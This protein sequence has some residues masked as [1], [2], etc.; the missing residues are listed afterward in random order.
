VGVLVIGLASAHALACSSGPALRQTGATSGGGAS[1]AGTALPPGEVAYGSGGVPQ[2][3]L[4]GAALFGTPQLSLPL[5]AAVPGGGAIVAMS[6]DPAAPP[7]GIFVASIDDSCT[8]RWRVTFPTDGSCLVSSV[9]VGSGGEIAVAGTMSA[10]TLELGTHPITATGTLSFFVAKIDASGV[11]VFGKAFGNGASVTGETGAFDPAVAMDA[12][13]AVTVAGYVKGPIDFGGGPLPAS[14]GATGTDTDVFVAKLDAQGNYVY[15][16]RYGDA[17]SQVAN[18]VAIDSSGNAYVGGSFTGDLDLGTQE[19]HASTGGAFLIEVDPSGTLLHAMNFGGAEVGTDVGRVAIDGS[20]NIALAGRLV[21]SLGLGTPSPVEAAGW[22]V[23]KLDTDWNALWAHGYVGSGGLP[24]SPAMGT[25]G[26]GDTVVG[27]WIDPTGQEE[28]IDFGGGPISNPADG[29]GVGFLAKLNPSGGQVFS[30]GFS[31]GSVVADIAVETG[32]AVFI[33]GWGDGV[34][35]GNGVSV[36]KT[37][38][39][40]FVARFGP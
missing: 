12:Q 13:G 40:R 20:D 30:R 4:S 10:G 17:G 23:A 27:W 5:L 3:V 14:P 22:Y 36:P 11:P 34:N 9:A 37:A 31:V 33:A 16:R 35:L 38:D 15:A 18:A 7:A 25:D 28:T 39:G 24:Q 6:R 8:E 21:G 1:D 2:C 19:L 29:G 26:S 32:G